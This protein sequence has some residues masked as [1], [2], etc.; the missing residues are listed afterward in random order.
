MCSSDLL[1]AY[2]VAGRAANE[3]TKA[4]L[5]D[6]LQ[7]WLRQVLPDYMVPNTWM[8]LADLPVT[9]GG[10]IDRKALPSPDLSNLQRAYQPPQGEMETIAAAVWSDVLGVPRIGRSDGFFELGGHSLM[11]IQVVVRLRTRLGRE[12]PL[13][14]L[15]MAPTLRDFAQQI[16][17]TNRHAD[18][19][20][21]QELNAFMDSI[22][23]N[24]S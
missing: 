18:D 19:D 11:A 13:T 17:A 4:A 14:A 15:F 2:V 12:V 8:F 21:L 5:R 3:P 7:A 22:E 9:A 6:E 24:P 16:A 10:K 1:V 20:E 23:S